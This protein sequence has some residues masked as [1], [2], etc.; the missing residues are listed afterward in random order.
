M[1]AVEASTEA[2]FK[3]EMLGH[4]TALQAVQARYRGDSSAAI[5]L[6]LRALEYLTEGYVFTRSVLYM[7]LG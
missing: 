4:V 3:R 5:A 6:S 7:N 2:P 1:K